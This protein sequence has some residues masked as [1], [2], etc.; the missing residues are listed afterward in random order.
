MKGIVAVMTVGLTALSL[1]VWTEW[2]ERAVQYA[3]GRELFARIEDPA[4][5]DKLLLEPRRV[6]IGFL[7][8]ALASPVQVRRLRAH[9]QAAMVA[10]SQLNFE[11]AEALSRDALEPA[12]THADSEIRDAARALRIRWSLEAP[13]APLSRPFPEVPGGDAEALELVRQMEATRDAFRIAWWGAEL[14]ELAPR[15]SERTAQ[16]LAERLAVRV[17]TEYDPAVRVRLVLG[18]HA[19]GASW[20]RARANQ[21]AEEALERMRR[22]DG[23]AGQ[24]ILTLAIAAVDADP[25][26]F[27]QAADVV[28]RNFVPESARALRALD[29]LAGGDHFITAARRITREM[30]TGELGPLVEAFELLEPFL[31][32]DARAE[33]G[34]VLVERA[35]ADPRDAAWLAGFP[36]TRQQLQHLAPLLAAPNAPCDVVLGLPDDE[37]ELEIVRQLRNPRCTETSWRRLAAAVLDDDEDAD[38]DAVTLEYLAGV[39]DDDGMGDGPPT[40]DFRQLSAKLAM[41]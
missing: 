17:L 25:S 9:E 36:V 18:F 34:A 23:V 26:Y 37:R 22:L 13:P 20:P 32:E 40:V 10:L 7:R 41:P 19:V 35:A 2:R 39:E 16:H 33:A 8:E 15:L 31:P 24:R 28:M 3:R 27:R 21:F 29:W 6:R 5:F 4:V 14:R 38:E 1:W 11:E 30:R 12:L